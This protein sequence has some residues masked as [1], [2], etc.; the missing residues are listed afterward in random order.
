M[1]IKQNRLFFN[2]SL[3]S[4]ATY[5]NIESFIHGDLF[6]APHRETIIGLLNLH[7]RWGDSNKWPAAGARYFLGLVIDKFGIINA[8]YGARQDGYV[9]RRQ[10]KLDETARYLF[11]EG[12]EP[13]WAGMA[14]ALAPKQIRE[15]C[16]RMDAKQWVT[17]IDVDLTNITHLENGAVLDHE[18]W[19]NTVGP[20]QL[21][22]Y[23][24]MMQ[25][26]EPQFDPIPP[27]KP[28]SHVLNNLRNTAE[29]KS[30]A[31]HNCAE[32]KL[33]RRFSTGLGL[34][35][36][37]NALKTLSEKPSTP[38]PSAEKVQEEVQH[39]LSGLVNGNGQTLMNFPAKKTARRRKPAKAVEQK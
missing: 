12:D 29:N 4:A 7:R 39:H 11:T 5:T 33:S 22:A 30:S 1:Y 16:M 8:Y 13:I 15:V 10:Y 35:V 19:G 21:M 3:H 2:P 28:W 9:W 32:A 25:F 34:S 26:S 31:T 17:A 24:E 38:T 23:Q 27:N 36:Q 6:V 37:D 14:A 20:V 18:I